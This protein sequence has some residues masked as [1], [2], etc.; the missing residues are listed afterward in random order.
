MHAMKHKNITAVF[1][2][3]LTY[4]SVFSFTHKVTLTSNSRSIKGGSITSL[5]YA[6]DN[7]TSGG[8]PLS[9][10]AYNDDALFKFHMM[11]QMQKIRDYSAMDTYVNTESLW[12]LAWHDSFVRNGLADFVPPLTDGLSVLV[13][14]NRF[15]G[16]TAVGELEDTKGDQSSTSAEINEEDLDSTFV[17]ADASDGDASDESNSA[18][19]SQ[20]SSCSFLAAVFNDDSTF[21]EDESSSTDLE[22]TSYDCIMDKGVMADLCAS[23]D[24]DSSSNNYKNKKD[25]ARLLYEAT[26]RIRES[27]VYVANT[28]PMSL[29]TKEYLSKLGEY[30]GLQWEFDLDGISDDNLS[31]SVARKFGS[32]PTIG[33]QSMA[34]MIE[35]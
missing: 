3:T 16:P 14:G 15:Q 26:K 23:A 32:C 10:R 22:F 5:H 2:F 9:K 28:S 35:D 34:K 25:I 30:L 20:D 29:E 17:K 31:V 27:G 24:D 8:G 19:Q 21:D 12:N 4:G 13:V 6:E 11:T 7:N 33:W 18:R 1:F